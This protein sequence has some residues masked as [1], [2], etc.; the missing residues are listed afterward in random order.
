MKVTL[1]MAM[2]ANGMIAR[3]NGDTPWSASEWKSYSK[4][5]RS[6]KALIIGRRTYEIMKKGN[7]FK[8]IG[9]P[10][11]V[12]VS[13]NLRICGDKFVSALGGTLGKF[14]SE[15]PYP[16]FKDILLNTAIPNSVFLGNLIM[17][18]EV[19]AGIMVLVS[20]VYLLLKSKP[21]HATYLLLAAGLT[22]AAA[23]NGLFWLAAGWTSPSTDGL[24][25]LMFLVEVTGVVFALQ[26]YSVSK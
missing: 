25:M 12:V 23:L 15:N 20:G 2:T 19:F 10:F 3:K 1:Y 18:A 16:W 6:H 13:K 21:E 5:V 22:I 4:S 24:N 7:D 17:L 9:N 26:K 11:V 8:R 14:A